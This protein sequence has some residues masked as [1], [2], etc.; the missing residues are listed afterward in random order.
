MKVVCSYCRAAMGEKEPLSDSRITHTMCGD[1]YEHF[2]RLWDG[3]HLGEF[4]D[5]FDFP[6]ALFDG[7]L[8]VVAANQAMAER[9]G[10][11]D[12]EMFG[13]LGGEVLECA[14]ARLPEGCGKTMC[15]KGCTVR[16]AVDRAHRG[17]DQVDVPA[18]VDQEGGRQ[19]LRISARLVDGVV[20]LVIDDTAP[21]KE[22]AS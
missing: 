3:L 7:D 13:L 5:E 15:C 11:S 10:K 1:C 12:R 6:V 20:R 18:W 22:R 21:L 16:R 9:L 19:E 2:S 14:H 17:V 8:R 4:L